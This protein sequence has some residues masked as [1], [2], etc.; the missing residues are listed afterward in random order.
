[1]SWIFGNLLE[2]D[3][4]PVIININTISMI[5]AN[6]EG[7]C[8]VFFVEPQSRIVLKESHEEII[9]QISEIKKIV[10]DRDAAV[11]VGNAASREPSPEAE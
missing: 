11:F 6:Q 10:G 4:S 1:M 7:G 3:G 5:A 8:T 2:Y 9:Q